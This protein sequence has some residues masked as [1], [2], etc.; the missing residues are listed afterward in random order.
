MCRLC[1]VALNVLAEATVCAFTFIPRCSLAVS[2]N[3]PKSQATIGYLTPSSHASSISARLPRRCFVSRPGDT[4][5][6]GLLLEVIAFHWQ[7]MFFPYLS[8]M[9]IASLV[10]NS[11]TRTQ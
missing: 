6:Q 3:S 11:R 1:R 4:L 2:E 9:K 7:P 8:A 10:A 5:Q